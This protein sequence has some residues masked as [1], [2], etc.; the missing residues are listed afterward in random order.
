[1]RFDTNVSEEVKDLSYF[2]DLRERR[3][4]MARMTVLIAVLGLL[5]M[6]M[7]VLFISTET[8]ILNVDLARIEQSDQADLLEARIQR[9]ERQLEALH[10]NNTP[11][12]AAEVTGSPSP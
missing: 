7:Y 9:L 12:K 10:A 11:E 8:V 2:K 1:M 3:A 5:V 4:W 6:N